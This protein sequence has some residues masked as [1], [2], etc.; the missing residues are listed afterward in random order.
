MHR[1]GNEYDVSCQVNTTDSVIVN[2][3]VDRIFVELYPK[4]S[5]EKIDRAFYDLTTMYRGG[6][7]GYH[8]CDTAYHDI[9]HVL[10]VTLAMSRLIDGYERTRIGLEPLD[11]SMFRLGVIT[12]LF[13]D[14]GYIR[15]LHDRKHK[16][17][18]ELTLTHVS[19]GAR[20]LRDYLPKIGMGEDAD[21]A[22]ALIHFTGYEIPVAAI[23]VPSLAHRLLGSLLGSADII[24]QMSDRCYLEKCRDRLY[25][26]FV[27][28]GIA[29]R[30][31][32]DGNE[33]VV[34]RSGDDLV[35]KTPNFYRGASRR[36]DS[37]LGGTHKYAQSHFG[38]QH[39]YMEELTKNIEFAQLI[40]KA[41]NGGAL[42]RNPPTTQRPD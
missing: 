31:L 30:R 12:A 6:R 27:A 8:A 2:S 38:G 26:E 42:K 40:D 19:R 5:T 10:E 13:H 41:G 32:P 23:R 28:G 33:E 17:G 39:L 9:Q 11:A 37:D 34:Y 24:A 29:R 35:R 18:G 20:F 21:V 25:P 14:C 36:L 22:A 15:T 16:N 4:A 1:R 3:E 7:P